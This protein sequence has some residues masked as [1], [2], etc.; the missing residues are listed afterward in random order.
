LIYLTA[1]IASFLFAPAYLC[2]PAE[3][4][5]I[6]ISDGHK[7]VIKLSGSSKPPGRGGV[8]AAFR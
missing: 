3:S 2:L 8:T 5:R 6:V 4:I 7:N 1:C